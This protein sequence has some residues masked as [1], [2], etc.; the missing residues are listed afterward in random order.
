MHQ[1]ITNAN[2]RGYG[3][4]VNE[5]LRIFGDLRNLGGLQRRLRIDVDH[6]GRKPLPAIESGITTKA[7][8]PAPPTKDMI[9]KT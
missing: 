5:N 8:N 6:A 1:R 4:R 7:M 3:A 2:T 9:G